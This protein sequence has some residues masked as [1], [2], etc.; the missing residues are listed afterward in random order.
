MLSSAQ[1]FHGDFDASKVI[2]LAWGRA[3][4]SFSSRAMHSGHIGVKK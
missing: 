1:G 2:L 4:F 3:L